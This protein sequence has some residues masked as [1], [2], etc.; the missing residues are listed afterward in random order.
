MVANNDA[1]LAEFNYDVVFAFASFE[2]KTI[3]CYSFEVRQEKH[4]TD[5]MKTISIVPKQQR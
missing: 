1:N 2:H 3:N 4:E 5:A